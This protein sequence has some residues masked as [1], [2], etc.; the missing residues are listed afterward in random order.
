MASVPRVDFGVDAVIPLGSDLSP[1][2]AGYTKNWHYKALLISENHRKRH[3]RWTG[4]GPFYTWQ[5]SCT[6][7]AMGQSYYWAGAPRGNYTAC[8]VI[9]GIAGV[10]V[11]TPSIPSF[12]SHKVDLDQSYATGFKR[13]RPGNP[14]ADV[15]QFLFELKSLPSIPYAGAFYYEK[16][17]YRVL[18]SIRGRDI[19]APILIPWRHIPRALRTRVQDYRRLGGEYLNAQFGWVPFI[20]DL[21]KFY[22]LTHSVDRRLNQ[23]IQENGRGINRRATISDET[24][25][26]QT[27]KNYSYP[28]ANVLG[29]PSFVTNGSTVYT[30]TTRTSTRKWFSG[31]FRYYVPDMGSPQWTF[32]ARLALFGAIP[33]PETV[34]NVMPWSWLIDWYGNVGDVV[35]NLSPNAV[36]YPSLEYSYIMK[37]VTVETEARAS[38][39][40][41]GKSDSLNQWATFEHDFRSTI[42]EEQKMRNGGGNPLG[43]GVKFESLS[44]Y[45]TSI[46]AALGISRSRVK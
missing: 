24:T 16:E 46:L 22:E 30:V 8:G 31:K 25:V 17:K 10:P 34:W 38:V 19:T 15:G 45:Q 18:K 37:H 39:Y 23:L 36:G 9:G 43:L 27:V 41:P 6:S 2:A 20:R 28:F 42:K 32:Q 4:G 1:G 12:A 11:T 26:S 44:G 14:V 21:R 13:A 3:G 40:H 35:S 29:G 5:K 33:T 7:N